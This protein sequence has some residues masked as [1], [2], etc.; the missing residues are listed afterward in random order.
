MIPRLFKAKKASLL[1]ALAF[2]DATFWSADAFVGVVFALYIVSHIEGGTAIH[3][4]FAYGMY[5]LIRGFAAVPLGR[6]FDRHKGHFD[7]Y[8]ALVF[9]GILVTSAYVSMFFAS[10]LWHVYVAMVIISVAHA[11][12]VTS[13]RILFYNNV[14][15]ET[16]GQVMG[17]YETTMQITYA[18][19]IVVA[20]FIGDNF[21][22]DWTMLFAG[23]LTFMSTAVIL[24]T[25]GFKR[26]M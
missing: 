24:T 7:E 8:Y 26:E 9:S 1:S 13:W 12:D 20:G 14:P 11:L 18:L 22:F 23:M 19:S 25:R 2:N 10:E 15:E 21:G 3:V 16:S 4:G 5:R 17:I 6:F